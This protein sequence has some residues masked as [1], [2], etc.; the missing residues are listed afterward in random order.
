MNQLNSKIF[1][2]V[3][4]K[5]TNQAFTIEDQNDPP[6]RLLEVDVLSKL[7]IHRGDLLVTGDITVDEVTV[8]TLN[9]TFLNPPIAG[10]GDVV[11]P[12]AST[13]NAIVRWD[14]VTG[15]VVQDSTVTIADSGEITTLSD[16]N[17]ANGVFSGSL[18][19]NSLSGPLP[20]GLGDVVGPAGATDE[21]IAIYDGATG[22]LLQN[23]LLTINSGNINR[24]GVSWIKTVSN[25]F[26]AGAGAHAA[27]TGSDNTAIGNQALRDN[28]T[29]SN[30]SCLGFSAARNNTTGSDNIAMGTNT[31]IL[32]TNGAD[33]TAIG[34]NSLINIAM[35]NNNIAMGKN[36]GN[37][38]TTTESDNI[39]IG[40]LGVV[41]DNNIMRLGTSGDIVNTNFTG[42]LSILDENYISI[43]DAG[44]ITLLNSATFNI[45]VPSVVP[46]PALTINMPAAPYDGQL[47]I[48]SITEDITA[49]THNG[50]GNTLINPLPAT[51]VAPTT[52][53]W[54]YRAADTTWYPFGGAVP[55]EINGPGASTDNAIV[56]WNGATG[57]L[58][59]DSL[60]TVDDTGNINLSGNS[61]IHQNGGVL[62]FAAG[63]LALTSI[64]T[65]T[66]NT[67]LGQQSLED[68]TSGTNNTAVGTSAAES[69]VNGNS[70]TAMGANALQ[71]VTSQNNNVAI[72]YN[73]LNTNVA[74]SN[75]A[76]GYN[77]LAI[78]TSGAN[79]TA[80]G[81]Q[82]LNTLITGT[83]N[84]ALGVNA[85]SSYTAAE[86]DN[87]CVGNV[88]VLGDTGEIR[89]GTSGTHN[90]VNAAGSLALVDEIYETPLTGSTVTLLPN[91]SIVIIDPASTLAALTVNMPAVPKDGQ[92][93]KIGITQNI[94]SLTHS[95]NG[96]TLVEGFSSSTNSPVTGTWYYRAADTTWYP[97]DMPINTLDNVEGPVSST[98]NA[99][100]RFDSTTGKVIQNSV[101]ELDDLGNITLSGTDYIHIN[102]GA[103]NFAAGL[104]ALSNIGT[105]AN[106]TCIG[107]SAGAALTFG[108]QNTLLGN[109]AGAS[110]TLDDSNVAIGYNTL[111]S[112]AGG[113]VQIVAVGHSAMGSAL[114][115][116]RCTAIGY[117]TLNSNSG[118]DNTAIGHDCMGGKTS[119]D[120]NTAIGS[121]SYG[122]STG[123][124]NTGLGYQNL[125]SLTSGDEN[126]AIGTD[127]LRLV[128]S[129]SNNI[130]L[131]Y[132]AGDNL[133][134]GNDN[135]YIG[136]SAA[137]G[138]ETGI[139][140]IG[141]SG[142]HLTNF[143]EGIRGVSTGVAD[144]IAVLIDSNGQL[145]TASSSKKYKKNILSLD[146]ISDEF[147]QLNPVSFE[148]KK[149]PRHKQYGLIAE[150]VEK[151]NSRLVSYQD[152]EIYS[153]RYHLLHAYYIKMIQQLYKKMVALEKK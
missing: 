31:L 147:M 88:G 136:A 67:A 45:I 90:T 71:S 117:N 7:I 86:S 68:L 37:A 103:D 5:S 26:A 49:L 105:G 149:D 24:S 99:I 1:S 43:G 73:A 32:N 140:R 102:G 124:D 4:I 15:G 3:S 30:N 64:T 63:E 118:T 44:P 78:N 132:T 134:T 56:R 93:I 108:S 29:G 6:Y 33:N 116:A 14:G 94:T 145:G 113:A 50:N 100:A 51:I 96:N 58:I 104:G 92:I 123:S 39:C 25:N 121:T 40:N 57:N 11:G 85:A 146:N 8:N 21:A 110:M 72:G 59:Q 152:G 55:S 98:D 47:L 144:A 62:N 19:F 114:S 107:D 95:G 83:N 79:N 106:N 131:G 141:E 20:T 153:V 129:G 12:G 128:S 81:T 77:A 60:L 13:D 82:S 34:S 84:I 133:T 135:I 138:A 16:I 66:N 17:A 74:D 23:S 36:A 119:G 126:T 87:I 2:G 42:S 18:T 69:L 143:Q 53:Q 48:I 142:T 22:K 125:T 150:E 109:S 139:I 54:Y 91:S 41:G 65:G 122:V 148:Y 89:L 111:S 38:Y 52:L 9:Y 120:R 101:L 97:V 127:A 75:V 80:L 115:G 61:F 46:L 76:I 137:A 130:A 35:G 27:G 151:I 112:I 10:G 28:T 70:N